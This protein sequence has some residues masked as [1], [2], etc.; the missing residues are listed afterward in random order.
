MDVNNSHGQSLASPPTSLTNGDGPAVE[1]ITD[2]DEDPSGSLGEVGE[3]SS[4]GQVVPVDVTLT[5]G[6]TLR[7]SVWS[8]ASVLIASFSGFAFWFVANGLNDPEDIGSAQKLWT[9]VQFVNYLT[10]MGLPVAVARYSRGEDPL[11]RSLFGWAVVYTTVT[12]AV[13]TIGYFI[14]FRGDVAG[15]LSYWGYP[16]AISLFFLAVAGMSL[17]FLVEIRLMTL[18]RWGWVVLR[19]VVLGMTRFPLLW[20]VPIGDDGLWLFLLVAGTPALTGFVGV[21]MFRGRRPWGLLPIAPRLMDAFRYASVNYFG[22]LAEKAP[23]FV[24]P[25]VVA[26]RVDE[27]EFATFYYVWMVTLIVFLVPETIGRVLLVEGGKDGARVDHQVREGLRM[28]V[29][30]M[31]LVAGGAVALPNL[32]GMIFG[33][34]FNGARE[35]FPMFMVAGVPW[36]VTTTGLARARVMENGAQT[37]LITGAYAAATLVPSLW[38]VSSDGIDGAARAWVVGHLVAAA[39]AGVTLVRSRLHL[40]AAPEPAELLQGAAPR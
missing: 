35:V 33:E 16:G 29:P 38:L 32:I 39:V 21:A 7:G 37:V 5:A 25:V 11:A 27:V 9:A 3:P 13:G 20:L 1:V 12:S 6:H 17:A 15:R 31:M 40:G 23:A 10:S 2:G 8:V 14:V 19:V 34:E 22:L 26:V 28:G 36:V 30:L 18:R 4:A 24:L